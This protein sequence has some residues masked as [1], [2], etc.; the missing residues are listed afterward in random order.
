MF[1]LLK[2]Y[3][4]WLHTQWPAGEVE[5]LPRVHT[6]GSTNVP[7][8]YIVGDLTG[9]PLLKFSCDT[10]TKAVQTIVADAQFQ[11]ARKDS[12]ILDL[13]IIGGGV[14][15]MAAAL[16]ARKH[17]LKFEIVES[18]QAFS[19]IVNF[20]KAKPI[21]TYPTDMTPA[22]DLQVSA[23]VKEALVD[24]LIEQTLKQGIEPV[25]ARA[26][27]V[28]R[29]G[30]ELEVVIAGGDNKRAHRVIVAIGRSGN[31][32]RLGVPGEDLSKVSNRLHDPKD[33]EGQR[34]LVVGGGDS[35]LEAA[36][37]L[38]QCGSDVTLSYRKPEFNRPKP[39]NQELLKQLVADP[40]ADVDIE[41]PSSS[42]TASSTGRFL[43]AGLKDPGKG[44]R[45]TLEMASQVQRIE[46]HQVVIKDSKGQERSLDNDAVFLMI[47]REPPLHFFRKSGVEIIGELRPR[48]WISLTIF[49]LF[50]TFIYNWKAGASVTE[51]FKSRAWFPFSVPSWLG[52]GGDE[53]GALSKVLAISLSKPGFYYSLTYCF[54]VGLFGWTRIKRRKTPYV[55]VQTASLFAIQVIPLFL[56]PYILLPLFGQWGVFDSAWGQY[57]GDQLFPKV[58]YGHGR[59]YWRAFGFILAWPL[60]LWNVFTDK[61]MTLWLVISFIQ[62]FVLIPV[63]IFYWGKGAYCGWICSCGALAET[64]G[65]DHRHKMP[66]GPFW[67][68]LNMAGQVILWLCLAMFVLRVVG[69]ITPQSAIGQQ[70]TAIHKGLLQDWVVFGVQLN[71]K[72]L[73]DVGL[74]GILG[75]GL[76]FWYSG[77]VWCR[78]FCP[79]AALMHIYS[80]FSRF[81]IITD[82]KKCISCNAC[83]SVC[84][85]GIDVMSFANKGLPMADPECVRCSACVETCPTGV[86]EFGQVDPKTN[87][88]L[89]KD[90]LAAS[91][92]L[93]AETKGKFAV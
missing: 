55:K 37:A 35:A 19:T 26:E 24:E 8:L 53:A 15:G 61:P 4:R 67:N 87:E 12:E 82:K 60:F 48:D 23:D 21:Y 30:S 39:K 44:G 68:R 11:S 5:K 16:E 3:T 51:A 56:L 41:S 77:R 81:R 90:S 18:A 31:Y 80:R 2:N 25:P 33:Y 70:F 79:L 75:I 42:R 93:M 84:H 64:M 88:V 28:Q 57:F 34:S 92:V 89:S 17:E 59:E 1:K 58:N 46:D 50:C 13:V 27:F 49:V 38:A 63:M 40:K 45:I 22:G 83:T 73:V 74:A 86:L 72:W 20:P 7:G 32:R 36:I 9:I 66:H 71:Y 10:G 6:D 91:P 43:R 69:W 29:Q 52:L 78:F 76:Y 65:D 54:C 47:G 62:T 14:S 85:Q